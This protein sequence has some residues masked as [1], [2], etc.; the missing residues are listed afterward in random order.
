MLTQSS[1]SKGRRFQQYVRDMLLLKAP[2]L[3]AD[4]VRSTSMGVTGPD[5][6]LSTAAQLVY[7]WVIE[8]K[9]QERINV[10]K[11]W[12]Q[13]KAH[14]DVSDDYMDYMPILFLKKNRSDALVVLNADDFF[15]LRFKLGQQFVDFNFDTEE[16]E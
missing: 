11:A 6:Q 10:W 3:K 2:S 1:K 5:I 9:N 4:D 13:T 15:G 7:P 16:E 14:L 8:I 12:D